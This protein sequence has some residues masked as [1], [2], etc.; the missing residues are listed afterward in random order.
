MIEVLFW[1]SAAL[2]VYTH[3]GY[4]LVLRLLARDEAEPPPGDLPSVSLI[5]PAYDEEAVIAAKVRNALELDY[6]RDRLEVI[7]ASD[8]SSDR[9]VELAQEAGA[10]LV[11]DLPNQGKVRTQDQAVERATGAILAFSDANTTLAPDALR[12]LVAPFA[13]PE[14]GYVCGQ[15]RFEGTSANQEGAYW[16]YETAIRAFESR[17][18]GVTAGNGGL[19]ATRKE[20]YI[21]V[22][23][24]MGHDL[25]FPFN[26][27]KRGWRPVYEP[28]AQASEKTTPDNRAEGRRKRRM[29][30]HMWPIVIQGGMLSPRGYGPLY[31]WQLAS[32]RLLRYATPFLHLIALATNVALLGEGPVYAVTL[33]VQLAVAAAAVL[34]YVIPWR[35]FRLA[36]YYVLVTAS[37][38][39]GLWDWLRTGTPATWEKAEGTR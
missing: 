35:P 34:A 14:V 24:R 37:I 18:A 12:Q 20:S 19:Y 1:A 9:T 11:L 8:G 13:D 25:S 7:V 10:D 30:S 6:P 3:A 33:A 32:H 2:I 39:G 23:P 36:Q 28:R 22:D 27:V 15:V 4:P 5:V 31:A 38:L 16:R 17:L 29:M 21:V 26:M